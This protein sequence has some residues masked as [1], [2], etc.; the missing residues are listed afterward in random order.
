VTPEA[1]QQPRASAGAS[2]ARAKR[3]KKIPSWV[4]GLFLVIVLAI[5]SL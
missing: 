1:P 5:L 3:E 4:I 2:Q